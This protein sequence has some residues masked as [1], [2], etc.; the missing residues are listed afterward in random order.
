MNRGIYLSIPVPDEQD[1]IETA[2]KIAESYSN[3]LTIN[4]KDE[5]SELAQSYYEYKEYLSKQE[6]KKKR[7]SWIKRFL[8]FN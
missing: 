2:I 1:L 4:Y 3:S 5:I 6:E 8:S 7:F